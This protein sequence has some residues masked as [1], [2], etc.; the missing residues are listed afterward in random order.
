MFCQRV[1]T[2]NLLYS[3]SAGPNSSKKLKDIAQEWG[4]LIMGPSQGQ[5]E[6]HSQ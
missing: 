4:S 2:G 6:H 5:F 3:K 1:S